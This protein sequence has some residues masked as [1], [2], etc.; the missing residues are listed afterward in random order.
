VLTDEP[1]VAGYVVAVSGATNRVLWR[2]PHPADA[3]TLP[4]FADLNGDGIP[5]VVM[6]GR[7][8]ALAAYSGVDGATLWRTAPGEV[9]A[10]PV[11][12]NFYTPSMIHDV[13]GDGVRDLVVTYGGDDTRVPGAPRDP[14][15]LAVISGATGAVLAV[16][17]SP[18][19]AEIYASPLVYQRPDHSDWVVFGT[20]GETHGGGAYRAP[21]ASLL[22]GRFA[23][24][25]EPL[26]P[27]GEARGVMAPPTL[28]DLT[29][30][31]ELD[32]VVSAFDGRLVAV[33]GATRRVLWEARAEGE[34]AYHPP[35]VMRMTRDGRLGLFVSRGIGVFPRYTGSVHRLYDAADGSVVYEYRDPL[36]PAGAPLAVDLTGDGIDEPFF[37]S[38]RF[39]AGQ[40]ARIHFLHA[41]SRQ[42]IGHEVPTNL[43][44]TPVIADPRGTGT[45]ELI[46]LSWRAVEGEDGPE[47][48]RLRSQLLRFDLG[49]PAPASASWTGYMG[50]RGDGR[51]DPPAPPTR[52]R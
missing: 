22:D 48:E 6:G 47:W 17:P 41:A 14:G 27:P 25:V 18:D 34:E 46:A 20:G 33:E 3:F 7:E 10:T 50:S 24:R 9:A 36:S 29:G 26:V 38:A 4:R 1:A 23:E 44:T 32:L 11:P 49:A 16:H 5:D 43:T 51:F 42:L 2:V 39:P 35:A 45:L 31:G 30:D 40:G 15:Y 28:V 37:F 19:G 12:Y 52:S 13:D 21:L 8:G